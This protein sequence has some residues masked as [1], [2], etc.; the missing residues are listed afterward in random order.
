[1]SAVGL[2]LLLTSAGGSNLSLEEAARRAVARGPEVEAAR[3]RLAAAH[4]EAGVAQSQ[5]LPR[6]ELVARYSRINPIDNDPLV[7]LGFDVE[8]AKAGAAQIQDPA[9]RAVLSSQLDGLAGLGAARI[10]VPSD[11][12]ALSARLSYPVSQLF[13]EILPGLEAREEGAKAAA[14]QLDVARNIVALEGIEALLGLVRAR[15]ALAVAELAVRQ[16]DTNLSAARARVEAARGTKTDVLR[17]EARQ[18][19]SERRRAARVADLRR[20]EVATRTLLG[21]E[22]D[23]PLEP[24]LGGVP[25]RPQGTGP[26]LVARALEM[27]DELRALGRQRASA[28]ATAASA[29]GGMLPTLA[30]EA[31][32]AYENPSPLYVPPGDRFRDRWSLSAVLRW[33]PDGAYRAARVADAADAQARAVDAA[34]RGL[35]DLIRIEV[36]EAAARLEAALVG[37]SAAQRAETA[38]LRARDNVRGG[39]DEGVFDATDLIEAELRLEESRL[40]VVDATVG[41]WQWKSRLRRRIGEHL[42]ED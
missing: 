19:E 25:H 29:R 24:R 8:A 13:F 33:S 39:F 1:M 5:L 40:G 17:L 2:L 37:L 15:R 23:D 35:E 20:A 16:A 4:A 21:L 34:G 18:A 12:V 28:G 32:V 9:A 14:L 7:N 31:F 10:Q 42:W 6:L 38:A 11:Q 22:A 30:A 26:E 41:A 27:R 3:A 36:E